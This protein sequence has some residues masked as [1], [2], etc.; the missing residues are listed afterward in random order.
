MAYKRHFFRETMTSKYFMDG[1]RWLRNLHRLNVIII[2]KNRKYFAL[3]IG[4]WI[5]EQYHTSSLR[6]K[7]IADHCYL[8]MILSEN[9]FALNK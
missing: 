2:L 7:P 8:K 3:C 9:Q 5:R 6:F 1:S 4:H